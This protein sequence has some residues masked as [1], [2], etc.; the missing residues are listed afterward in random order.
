MT[1][2]TISS[3]EMRALTYIT[4]PSSYK[5][6]YLKLDEIMDMDSKLNDYLG[7]KNYTLVDEVYANKGVIKQ[8]IVKNQ[9]SLLRIYQY[10][11]TSKKNEEDEYV[12]TIQTTLIPL[13][14]DAISYTTEKIR[15]KKEKNKAS[16]F[17]I[18]VE[19]LLDTVLCKIENS[20]EGYIIYRINKD[21][22][23]VKDIIA[24]NDY[25]KEGK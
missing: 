4:K 23:E 3:F 20:I 11:I 12:I 7:K 18:N 10:L 25:H 16:K 8:N 1:T 6:L 14:I 2:I 21:L 13:L 22:N 5:R 24:F 19:P 15:N 17:E 9:L